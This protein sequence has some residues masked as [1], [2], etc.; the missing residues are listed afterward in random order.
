[1]SVL[2]SSSCVLTYFLHIY[3][4]TLHGQFGQYMNHIYKLILITSFRIIMNCGNHGISKKENRKYPFEFLVT[5]RH[6][7]IPNAL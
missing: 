3:R 5:Y 4:I 6:P 1:M 2:G 7:G